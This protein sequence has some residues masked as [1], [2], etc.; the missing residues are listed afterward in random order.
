MQEKGIMKAVP[1]LR[2]TEEEYL[3]TERLSDVRRE[4]LAR[5]WNM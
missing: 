5:C 2:L 4:Y 1:V 3:E